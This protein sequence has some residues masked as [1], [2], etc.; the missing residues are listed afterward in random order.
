M[1]RWINALRRNC[2][3]SLGAEVVASEV[4][5]LETKN[6]QLTQSVNVKTKS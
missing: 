5:R 6:A 4:I 3:R 2:A 1:N